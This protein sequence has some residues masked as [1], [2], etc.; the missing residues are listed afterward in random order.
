MIEGSAGA[1]HVGPH[2]GLESSG[3]I[4]SIDD[5][6]KGRGWRKKGRPWSGSRHSVAEPDVAAIER[7][8]I[9][10][11]FAAMVEIDVLAHQERSL[12]LQP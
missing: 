5:V 10:G 1:G 2:R 12:A 9:Q 11:R 8:A 7:A 3:V 6:A 4:V